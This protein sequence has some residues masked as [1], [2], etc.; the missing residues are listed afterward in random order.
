MPSAM[1]AVAPIQSKV[2]SQLA[3]KKDDCHAGLSGVRFRRLEVPSSKTMTLDSSAGYQN[4]RESGLH[5]FAPESG[6]GGAAHPASDD[7]APILLQLEPPDAIMTSNVFVFDCS[8]QSRQG[9]PLSSRREPGTALPAVHT[10]TLPAPERGDES[11]KEPEEP[12]DDE[13]SAPLRG[14]SSAGVTQG[15]PF[16][17][18]SDALQVILPTVQSGWLSGQSIPVRLLKPSK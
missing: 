7:L 1:V 11:P 9:Q 15:P 4:E 5:P 12:A 14:A 6:A 3:E 18:P 8:Q 17:P 16:D 2:D 10:C 13:P